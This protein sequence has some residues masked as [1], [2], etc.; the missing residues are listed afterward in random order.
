M[1]SYLKLKYVFIFYAIIRFPLH[2]LTGLQ[3]SAGRIYSL[4]LLIILIYYL[5]SKKLGY[6][7]LRSPLIYWGIWVVYVLINTIFQGTELDMKSWQVVTYIL[8]PLALM[9]FVNI[10]NSF[11]IINNIRLVSIAS[12]L[13]LLIILF[14]DSF[15]SYSD[16]DRLGEIMNSNEVGIGGLLCFLFLFLLYSYKDIKLYSFIALS[17]I[18]SYIVIMSGS[19][20]AFLPF[21]FMLSSLYVINRSKNFLK[22]ISKLLFGVLVM[23]FVFI[24]IL[25]QNSVIIDRLKESKN[26]G[27]NSINTG[28]ALDNM[29]S[30]AQYYVYGF[31]IFKE[32]K[33]FGVG[34]YNYKIYN[35]A[36]TQPN[37]VEIM[38]QLCELGIV[39]FSLF[40]LF[41]FWILKHLINCW[42]NDVKSRK[43]T[44]AYIVSYLSVFSLYFVA[45]TYMNIL[46]SLFLGITIAHIIETENRIKLGRVSKKLNSKSR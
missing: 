34:L 41:N 5:S 43:H 12:F 26:E 8:A 32:N 14:N 19:R 9:Y 38:I 7:T 27:E 16:G 35:P 29:G 23:I 45:Y 33:L 37:H 13:S 3:D 30:R 39:G 25:E 24:P 36:N 17:I 28:T 40:I 22:T 31:D 6:K 2:Q 10:R 15:T 44:E 20:S 1:G 21:F 18:P 42:R 11:Y 4:L 46:I